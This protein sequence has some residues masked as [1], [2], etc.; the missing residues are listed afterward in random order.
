MRAIDLTDANKKS[1]K[2]QLPYTPRHS[3]NASALLRTPWF[4]V[5]YTVIAVGLRY[6]LAQNIPAN[7]VQGYQDHTLTLSRNFKLHGCSVK[8]LGSIT[9]LLDKDY[10]VV[11]YYPMPG[12]AYH[13]TVEVKI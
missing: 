1:Y 11:R 3:G 12:R 9:N 10:D 4:N 7:E 2:N 6:V 5:G 13:L 8:L